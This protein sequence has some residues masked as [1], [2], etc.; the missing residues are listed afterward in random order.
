MRKGLV[1][2]VY[3]DNVGFTGEMQIQKKWE[4]NY[5]ITLTTNNDFKNI[6]EY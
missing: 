1:I 2:H 3:S 5:S 4:K 6:S